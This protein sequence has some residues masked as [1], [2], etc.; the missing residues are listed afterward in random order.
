[1]HHR[2]LLR[3]CLLCLAFTG[4]MQGNS[5]EQ[6]V[7]NKSAVPW[8]ELL[9]QVR[10]GATKKL[11]YSVQPVTEQQAVELR[12]LG[13]RLEVLEIDQ[14]TFSGAELAKLLEA[15]PS[16]RQLKLTGPVNGEQ[17]LAVLNSAGNLKVLNLPDGQFNDAALETLP[18]QHQLELLR[19]RSPNVSDAGL[20]AIAKFP[21]LRFLHLIEVPITDAGLQ[22]IAKIETLESF[23]LDGGACTEEGLSA[24]IGQRS[25][26]H[27]HWNQLHLDNDPHRHPH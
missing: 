20:E 1:M 2:E 8:S 12:G 9:T 6:H 15:L 13:D 4:C 10:S 17:L 26:L 19:F 22:T 24:L 11:E 23:Y 3:T 7:A 16:L 27:F 25:D 18:S 14:R 21:N 5:P